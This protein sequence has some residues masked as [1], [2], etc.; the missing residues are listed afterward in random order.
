MGIQFYKPIW[1]IVR[2]ICERICHSMNSEWNQKRVCVWEREKERERERERE[3]KKRINFSFYI[4]LLGNMDKGQGPYKKFKGYFHFCK[5]IWKEKL[6]KIKLFH[7][8][9]MSKSCCCLKKDWKI[10]RKTKLQTFFFYT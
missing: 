7:E 4:T 3:R 2:K 1:G 6:F 10:E 5:D 9:R 8:L